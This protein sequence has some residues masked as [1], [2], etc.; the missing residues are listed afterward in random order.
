MDN[1][2]FFHGKTVD[3]KKFTIA[4]KYEI[5]Q[6]FLKKSRTNLVLAIALCSGKDPFVK[7][8]G[9]IKAEGRLNS[10]KNIGKVTVPIEI[11]DH[12]IQT[13]I[14][15]VKNFSEI[16]SKTIQKVFNLQNN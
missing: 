7:K 9:R 2:L 4:G 16:D 12:G 5:E 11:D 1:T 10:N 6:S 13:F 3:N 15:N 8:V 14:N